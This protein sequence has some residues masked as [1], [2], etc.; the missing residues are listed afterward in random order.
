MQDLA[1][2]VLSNNWRNGYT[3]PSARLYP[4]QWNWDSGFIALGWAYINPQRAIE[5]V[6]TMFKGQWLN[7]NLPHINFHHPDA[8]YF[9]GPDIWQ[10]D[11]IPKVTSQLSTSGIT[12]PP[13]FGF[14]VDE[15]SELL[16]DKVDDL[17]DFLREIYPKILAFHRYLYEKRDPQKEGLVYIQHNWE[18]GTDN[19]PIWDDILNGMNV[20]NA[21]DVSSLR[22]DIKN[23]DSSQRPTNDNYVRYLA[24]IDLYIQYGYRDEDIAA[25][26]PF[27][28]QDVL[29]NSLLVKSNFGLINLAKRLDFDTAEIEAWN[30]K[31]I[32][33]I[34]TKLWDETTGFYYAYDLRNERSVRIKTS[35]G[36]APLYGGICNSKQAEQL[37]DHLQNT[38]ITG[39]DWYLCPSTAVN[40]PSFNP[41]KYWRGPVWI[42]LNWMIIQGLTSYGYGELAVRVKRDTLR[43]IEEHGMYEYFDPR[44]AAEALEE[45]GI[46]ADLF[47]WTAA[48]Y[49][50]LLNKH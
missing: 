38:F 29:F 48:L 42:N 26:C 27:L 44:P 45:R 7:G 18:S 36:F 25:H 22:R 30:T 9:P 50:D 15:L 32:R 19:S 6:N 28:V 13:V 37:V 34:N 40:E 23:V 20:E 46:G 12:Q 31:T 39:D 2:Q 41:L 3:I 43:L 47:S 11:I 17:D 24:L 1:K 16:A 4:F 21:R 5:E 49:L 10:T 33:A 8:N 35:S 14:I